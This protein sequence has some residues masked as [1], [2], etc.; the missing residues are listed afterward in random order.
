MRGVGDCEEA[1]VRHPPQ[2]NQ[3]FNGWLPTHGG[4]GSPLTQGQGSVRSDFTQRERTK[5]DTDFTLP[6]TTP[7]LQPF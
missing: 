3:I 2:S 7:Y 4:W 6:M 1:C 5:S